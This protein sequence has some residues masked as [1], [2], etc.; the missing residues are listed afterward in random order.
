MIWLFVIIVNIMAINGRFLG[1]QLVDSTELFAQSSEG[2]FRFIDDIAPD[3]CEITDTVE[4][5]D[6]LAE[7]ILR[8]LYSNAQESAKA[9]FFQAAYGVRN[10]TSRGMSFTIDA[11]IHEASSR[12][13]RVGGLLFTT[14]VQNQ[15]NHGELGY[16]PALGNQYARGIE[17]SW[18]KLWANGQKVTLLSR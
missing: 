14:F 13:E 11:S 1:L 8:G 15:D 7:Q 10:P 4:R 2:R 16:P 12:L 6:A 3:I 17:I 5:V 18:Q 9:G